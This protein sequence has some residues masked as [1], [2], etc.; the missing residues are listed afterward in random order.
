ML[1]TTLKY[2][3]YLKC[4]DISCPKK[5]PKCEGRY[6][7]SLNYLF[8]VN[9]STVLD[10]QVLDFDDTKE[11]ENYTVDDYLQGSVSLGTN[12]L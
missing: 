2:A 12:C 5:T 10:S 3:K 7:N 8:A 4:V 6:P 9:H 11:G 1:D